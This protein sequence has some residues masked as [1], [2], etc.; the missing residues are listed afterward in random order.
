MEHSTTTT[1]AGT[2]HYQPLAPVEHP[3][4]QRSCLV[5]GGKASGINFNILTVGMTLIVVL[6]PFDPSS[7]PVAKLSF[8]ETVSNHW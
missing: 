5:C 7:A 8:E 2:P 1:A 4:H 3:Q 6:P